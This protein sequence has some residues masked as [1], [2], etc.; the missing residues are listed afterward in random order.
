MAGQ[1]MIAARVLVILTW[2]EAA[3]NKMPAHRFVPHM[4]VSFFIATIAS[5]FAP[6]IAKAG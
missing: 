6:E 4:R 3:P 2:V 1:D 5:V